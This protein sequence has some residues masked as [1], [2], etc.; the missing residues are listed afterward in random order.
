MVTAGSRAIIVAVGRRSGIQKDFLKVE[1]VALAPSFIPSNDN[2]NN[3]SII[4]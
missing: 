3:H 4:Y 2:N 1:Y